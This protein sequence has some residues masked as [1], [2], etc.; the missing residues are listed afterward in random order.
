MDA[1][2]RSFRAMGGPCE[3]R[4]HA[5]DPALAEEW[6][7]AAEGEVRR[8]E[9]K[10]SRYRE[11][12]VCSAINRSAG[13]ARG[14]VVDDETAA[15]LDYAG[16][17]HAQ[18][19]GLFDITSG[20]LRR[21]WDWKSGVPPRSGQLTDLLALVGWERIAWERPRVVLPAEGM[22]LD[23][24]GYGK[25]YAV[26]RV[27][28]LL[29]EAGARHGTVNLA[30]DVA[31][32]GPRPDGSAW[33]V[34]IRHPR[35][36]GRALLALPMDRGALA[37]SGDYERFMEVDGRRLCHVLDPR[38]GWPVEALA[39]VSVVSDHCLVAGTATTIAMLKGEDGPA[40]LAELGLPHLW[41]ARDGRRGG[42]LWPDAPAPRDPRATRSGRSSRADAP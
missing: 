17:A 3:V 21:A 35:D 26:D 30:G 19:G 36:P 42:S 27:V 6:L 20:V 13:D 5:P 33:P 38:T 11:D 40:W 2:A 9:A 34:G 4:V 24:G 37:S 10:Y 25:E 16:I 22:E 7:C 1:Y 29:R 14:V 28:G 32:V 8:L 41:I 15:L 23:L 18:S 31:I 12:S 39:A